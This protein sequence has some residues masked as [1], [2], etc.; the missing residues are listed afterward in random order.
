MSNTNVNIE[1]K[2]GYVVTSKLLHLNRCLLSIYGTI[3]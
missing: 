2:T 1:I 3:Y